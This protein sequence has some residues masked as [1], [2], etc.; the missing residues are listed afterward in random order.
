MKALRPYEELMDT[1]P[2]LRLAIPLMAGIVCG[3]YGR[4]MLVDYV[5]VF[6]GLTIFSIAVAVCVSACRGEHQRKSLPFLLS[7]NSTMIF[8]GISL[9]LMA[10]KNLTVSWEDAPAN[11]RAVIVDT[12]K[13]KDKVWQTTIRVEGGTADGK[14]VRV[15]LMKADGLMPSG[16]SVRFAGAERGTVEF[17]S[18]SS[19]IRPSVRN[20]SSVSGRSSSPVRESSS[21][22]NVV[23]TLNSVDASR[24]EMVLQSDGMG[25]SVVALES[26][27]VPKTKGAASVSC[28]PSRL[29]SS[30]CWAAGH[31]S[32]SS[33]SACPLSANTE[34]NASAV[35][36]PLMTGDVLL[37]HTRIRTPHNAGNPSEFDFAQWL[38]HQGISGSAFCFVSQWKKSA[39][40]ADDISLRIRVLRWRDA[41]VEKYKEYFD[42]RELAVLAAMTLGDKTHLDATTRDI[43]SQT[44]VSHVLA[45]S[46]FHLSVLFSIYQLLVLSLCR[47]SGVHTV[48]SVLGIF[49]LWIFALLAGLP[50]SLVR[51]A[52]MFSV[53][54]LLG[55]FRRDALSVNNLSLAAILLLVVSPQSLFDVGFQLSF[56]SVF[57]I[58][59]FSKSFPRP[60]VMQ[61][62]PVV[63]WCY[64]LF[65][66]SFCAQ[67]GTAPLV[68]YYFHTFPVYGWL[69][70][71]VA[72]PLAY[73]ILGVGLL[74]F[75]LPFARG[76]L[77]V[78]LGGSLRLMDSALTFLSQLPG[79]VLELYPALLTVALVYVLFYCVVSYMSCRRAWKLYRAIA[80]IAV[81]FGIEFY[82]H[83]PHRLSPQ[84]LFYNVRGVPVVH[85]LVSA[86][87][88][89]AWTTRESRADSALTSVKKT[90][91]KKEK[92]RT[93]LWMTEK[94][95]N[96]D[97]YYD[98]RLLVFNGVRVALMADR[99][100]KG[101][102]EHPLA[103]DYLL[104]ARGVRASLDDLLACYLP[105]CVV[106]DGSLTDFY[107]NKYLKEMKGKNIRLH[108]MESQGA[109]Q[110]HF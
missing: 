68:A 80:L 4:N 78:V 101:K 36:Q 27:A 7:L 22:K 96:E 20:L 53:V 97:I 2:L 37:L 10:V 58:I 12:P 28:L 9:Q 79:A 72:V 43:F 89:Y 50:L 103:V 104:L 19:S 56:I 15:A 6:I 24:S 52:V 45:L 14:L 84:M 11:Y 18:A 75:V 57:F 106:L 85:A 25:E 16:A 40:P 32:G 51:A 107:R 98:G 91:W 44:G 21:S 46:G 83:R 47:R 94:M 61:R 64:D 54:Q 99:M 70:N 31:T 81:V 77:V 92:I 33:L 55:S 59:L 26:D 41:L 93:P 8:L 23:A 17:V 42:G 34:P 30:S 29:D 1:H 90:F 109:L 87:K 5:S 108:D 95:Q 74:F 39:C 76:L 69:S 3:E 110:L 65:V 38:R 71:F 102:P 88:S 100:P 35:S 49:G 105:R 82:V 63:G 73:I 62:I 86:E 13:E 67:L 48:M 60:A 66:V